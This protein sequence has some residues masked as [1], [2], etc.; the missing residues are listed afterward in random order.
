MR[1][2]AM[3]SAPVESDIEDQALNEEAITRVGSVPMYGT[4]PYCGSCVIAMCPPFDPSLF[5]N[6]L[7]YEDI[8]ELGEGATHRAAT[9]IKP[10][11][12][13]PHRVLL[14][15]F[16]LFGGVRWTEKQFS[17]VV[18][19]VCAKSRSCKRAT[20][21]PKSINTFVEPVNFAQ[22]GYCFSK[23]QYF[24]FVMLVR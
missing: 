24:L 19:E 6:T 2:R 15:D 11:Q 22:L 18:F 23:F 16:C 17:L 13:P 10:V 9:A 7:D 8:A 4:S 12:K 21:I 3:S 5:I 1:D 20:M 14:V